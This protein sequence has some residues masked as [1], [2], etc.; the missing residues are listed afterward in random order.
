M[1]T[2]IAKRIS[3]TIRKNKAKK[4]GLDWLPA[5]RGTYTENKFVTAWDEMKRRCN[6]KNFKQYKDYGGR[7][8][9]VCD[10]WNIF[11]Y[12][13][14]DMWS[15]YLIHIKKYGMRD[16]TLDRINSNKGYSKENCKW[17]T[18]KEQQYNRTN[19][20]KI[21]GKTLEYW[22]KKLNVSRKVLYRR[23]WSKLPE[24]QILSKDKLKSGRKK[25]ITS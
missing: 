25:N 2:L 21:K 11:A 9:K 4:Y 15:S 22:S 8:I 24:E 14:I 10:R 18:R 1:K 17:S 23:Y 5:S 16:T 6:N 13:F 7:G 20:I 19:T 12:F 3:D